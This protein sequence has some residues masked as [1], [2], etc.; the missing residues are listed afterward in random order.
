MWDYILYCIVFVLAVIVICLL[1]VLN[2]ISNVIKDGLKS[3]W[4]R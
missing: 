3:L 1:I 2:N 4:R